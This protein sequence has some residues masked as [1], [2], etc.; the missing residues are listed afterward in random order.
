MTL[1]GKN[2]ADITRVRGVERPL[3]TLPTP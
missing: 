3:R 2:L 1:A